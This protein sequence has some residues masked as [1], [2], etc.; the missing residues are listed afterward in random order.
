MSPVCEARDTLRWVLIHDRADRDAIASQL[1][2]Y[3]DD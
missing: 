1:L 2:R 3:H